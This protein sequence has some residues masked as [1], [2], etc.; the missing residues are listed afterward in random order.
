MNL[1]VHSQLKVYWKQIIGVVLL[2]LIFLAFALWGMSFPGVDDY[3]LFSD[4]V[5]VLAG[6]PYIGIFSQ[7]GLLLWAACAAIGF[8]S[9]A[10]MKG[11]A[12]KKAYRRYMMACGILCSW[13]AIDDAFLLHEYTPDY[14]A[15]EEAVVLG[16]YILIAFIFYMAFY[17]T[18]LKTPFIFLGLTVTFL[19]FS[20]VSDFVARYISANPY[21]IEEWPK[22]AGLIFLTAYIYQ[23]GKA[24]TK[25]GPEVVT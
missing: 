21:L 10:L 24:V 20:M 18:I 17:R 3:Q 19:A 11:Q 22:L 14:F 8:F 16:L 15:I 9:A 12:D 13:M 2:S 6:K 1:E 4:P 25:P 7:I 23:T 5:D